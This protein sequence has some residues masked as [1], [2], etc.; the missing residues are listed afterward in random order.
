MEVASVLSRIQIRALTYLGLDPAGKT[1]IA[2]F[3][4]AKTYYTT[5]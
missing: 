3:L 5:L 1:I 4:S 2:I